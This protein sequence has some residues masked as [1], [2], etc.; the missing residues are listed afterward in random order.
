VTD[1]GDEAKSAVIA[2]MEGAA[3][4][5]ADDITQLWATYGAGVVLVPDA[6]GVTLNADRHRIAFDAKTMDVFWLL[7]FAGWKAIEC[8][9]PLVMVSAKGEQPIAQVI[10]SDPNLGEF[11]RAYKERCAAARVLI[12][13][14][15]PA[16]APWPPDIPRPSASRPAVDDPQYKAAFDLSCL[17]AAF[18]VFHE[19]RHLMLAR[20]KARPRDVREDEM[21][22]DVWAR[23]FMIVKLATYAKEHG[24]DYQQVLL[25]RSMGLALAALIL[26][27]ITPTWD[28]GGAKEY[29]SVADRLRAILGNTPLP[30]NSHFWVFAASLL[31]GICRQRHIAIDAP[32]MSARKLARY[33]IDRL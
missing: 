33:L 9:G 24:H 22:C 32:P 6:K 25:K 19:F 3:P 1:S 21:A 20:D 29:F 7:A 5:R 31:I 27:E 10:A 28:Y 16:A 30:D 13:A 4:E 18:A 8:Y 14:A 15:D 26:N 12:E 23:E 2:L 17:A 11:E